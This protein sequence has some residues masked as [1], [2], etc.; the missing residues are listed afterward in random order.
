VQI[1]LVL[2]MCFMPAVKAAFIALW[3]SRN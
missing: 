1:V 3:I 2:I